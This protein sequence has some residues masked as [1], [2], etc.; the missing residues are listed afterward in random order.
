MVLCPRWRAGG[1]FI[2]TLIGLFLAMVAL[3]VEILHERNKI[4]NGI[5]KVAS[6]TETTRVHALDPEMPL[7]ATA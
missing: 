2:A 3:A 7:V 1:V 4:S 5:T 6:V